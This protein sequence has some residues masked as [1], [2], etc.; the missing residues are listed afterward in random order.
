MEISKY[1]NFIKLFI[2][3][4]LLIF[5]GERSPIA[6][7]E[8]YYILQSKW[9]L[10]T[11]DWISP[12]YWGNLVLD[13]TI[14]TQFL[15]AL[16][17]KIFGQNDFAIYIPNI[18]SGIIM[19]FLTSK[20]HKE[21]IG[22]KN[23]IFS[24][25]ILSTTFLWIN[26]FHMATQDIT[27]SAIVTFGIFSTIKAF[28]TKKP[29]FIFFSGI[30]LGLAVMLKTYLTTIPFLA[31][32]PFL[33]KT[34]IIKNKYF[35]IGTLVGFLP[36]I[37]WSYNII[38]IYGYNTFSGLYSKLLLLSKNNNY[39]YNQPFYYYLW[40]LPANTFPWSLFSIIGF[41]N[42]SKFNK[43]SH[44]FLFKYPLAIMIFLSI[45]STKTS[46]YPIQILPLISINSYFGLEY[47][48]TKR[49]FFTNLI[50]KLY[51]YFI[52]FILISA[53]VYFNL[54]AQNSDIDISLRISFSIL[55]IS[56]SVFLFFASQ[57]NSFRKKF[58]LIF[59]GPYLLL[60]VSVQSGFLNDRSKEIRVV[61][62]EIIQEENLHNTKVDFITNGPRDELSTAKLIKI[63]IFMPKIGQGIKNI[64][65]LNKNHYAWTTFPV[66]EIVINK[67][68]EVIANNEI[69]YPWK[70]I[71]K[72]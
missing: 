65:D 44:Y 13:R 58:F 16:S 26:F 30:W 54:F 60:S 19:L 47:I 56:F 11:N 59:L 5:I 35:W 29:F 32:L 9:I 20:I 49:T 33:I 7:D 50:N 25:L 43:L 63:A 12:T 24:A 40:N 53:V 45:F 28:K 48:Y 42:L 22:E 64:E 67:E 55:L 39:A 61:A 71:Y 17:Q 23:Q 1:R 51:F 46:Y 31:L 10:F 69:L 38:S 68:Y 34:K 72:K 36:F 15:I 14:A 8:G 6:F 21:L 70:L 27:F 41:F 66:D 62:Q 18:V 57:I 3:A 4:P 2:F 52:P 37:L